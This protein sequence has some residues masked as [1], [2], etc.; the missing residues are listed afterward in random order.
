[1]IDFED[2]SHIMHELRAPLTAV[3]GYLSLLRDGSF[4]K[5][6]DEAKDILDKVHA[7][8]VMEIYRVND[9]SALLKLENTDK[10]EVTTI[11]KKELA[12]FVNELIESYRK[13][14]AKADK[15]KFK[16]SGGKNISALIPT[17]LLTFII[18]FMLKHAVRTGEE[19]AD[20]DISIVQDKGS[21]KILIKDS[22]GKLD[23]SD[24]ESIFKPFV[25][26]EDGNKL[27]SGLELFCC[28]QAASYLPGLEVGVLPEYKD[29]NTFYISFLSYS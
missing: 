5:L 6:P 2:L 12:R 17:K 28:R 20:I 23:I 15:A 25:I 9:L 26:N 19:G 21:N 3:R 24:P 18:T 10:S 13:E 27:G 8:T 4:G 11:E 7:D 14:E 16:V 29:G 1:M 22:S